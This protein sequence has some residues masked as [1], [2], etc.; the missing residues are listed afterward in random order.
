[1]SIRT[2]VIYTIVA[3]VAGGLGMAI[4][5]F[6]DAS[7]SPISDWGAWAIAA[8]FAIVG[9]GLKRALPWLESILPANGPG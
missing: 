7:L 4:Q 3:F 8:G 2:A 1:M 6:L 9:A 5:L